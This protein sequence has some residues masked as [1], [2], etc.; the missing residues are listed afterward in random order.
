MWSLFDFVFPG[1]L[2]TLP[3]FEEQFAIPIAAGT[4]ANASQFKIQAARQCS[5]L[6]RDLLRPYLLRRLKADVKIDM[7]EK[8]EKV[9]FCHLTD[10]Q[11]VVYEEYLEGDFVASVLAGRANAFAALTSVLKVC[12]HPHL[13]KWDLGGDRYGDWQASGK[14]RV[15]KQASRAAARWCFSR[16]PFECQHARAVMFG[17]VDKYSTRLASVRSTRAARRCWA[18]A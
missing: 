7:P 2:G 6:L 1:K 9:L 3:V 15:L 12:N 10:E 17:G 14:M 13:L 18:G 4:Y 8:S 11:R 16:C 5:I